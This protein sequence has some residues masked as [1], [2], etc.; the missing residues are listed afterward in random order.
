M[1]ISLLK[2][3]ALQPLRGPHDFSII[4][5]GPGGSG[6]GYEVA[7]AGCP[8]KIGVRIHLEED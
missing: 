3:R 2:R 4:I 6:K 8:V 5:R 7:V 1:A